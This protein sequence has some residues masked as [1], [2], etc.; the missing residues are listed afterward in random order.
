[1]TDTQDDSILYLH[2][3]T[4]R[5][6]WRMGSDSNALELS[7]EKGVTSIAVSL[8]GYQAARIREL[9]GITAC[10]TLDVS[11][12]GTPICLYLVGRKVENQAWAGTAS[13][14]ED[15][16][17]VA[18]DL[19]L[20]LSFAEQVVSEANSVI[21][22]IDQE[23]K[24]HRFNRLSEEYTG[25]R[26]E[27]VI[28]RSAYELF[29]SM[30]E[31]IASRQNIEGFFQNKQSYEVERWINTVKGQR[32][33]L[34][35]NKFVHSGS[36]KQQKFLICSGSDI[37]DER[38]AQERLRILA[39]TDLITGLANRNALQERLRKSLEERGD[40]QVGLIYLDLDNFKK[41]N[42]AYGH[43]FGDRLLKEVGHAILGCLKET[44]TLARLGGDEFIILSTHTSVAALE[45]TS[46]QI[47]GRLKAPFRIGLI[48]V[49]TACSSGIAV[50]PQHGSDSESLLRNADTAMYV[51]KETGKSA[52]CVFSPEMNK[53]VAEYMW[54]DTHLRKAMEEHQLM[55]YYQPKVATNGDVLSVEALLRWRSP[56]RGI[57]QPKDFIPYAEESGLIAPLG[58]WVIDTATQQATD[59][60]RKGMNLR[61]AVNLS[62]RQLG[63]ISLV[64]DFIE[65]MQKCGM[66][67][68]L[69]DFE[70]TESYLVEDEKAAVD[71]INQLHKLGAEVHLD[72]FGTGYSSLSQLARIPLDSIKL[73]QSFVHGINHNTISQA[74]VRAIVAVARTL[75]LTVTAEGVETLEEASLLDEI[76][77]DSKQGFLFAKPMPADELEHW[78]VQ[79]ALT[80]P[81]S[82]NT[83]PR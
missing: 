2:L 16:A 18:H 83:A 75:Q 26:E 60:Q 64:T 69:L 21:V 15:T 7:A 4:P 66:K 8:T 59:W 12:F 28:G 39:N 13:D 58:K 72:D 47:L 30:E 11:L 50:C 65:T 70:L 14:F 41:V 24:V 68:C 81:G 52:H 73:D 27:D 5:P 6:Y 23:G 42:D 56:E 80:S 22:I 37:T 20:G 38:M 74:L 71:M 35:R 19:E 53:K 62:A 82:S 10:L 36:G 63:N 40:S 54:L 32:L 79:R 51:A 78:L 31:G 1:M 9:T 44:D 33:F 43:M 29:M 34:F 46:Q 49:Y 45:A 3:G 48:E 57:I 76:G 67:N 55:L 17:S 25:L 61:I 77:V